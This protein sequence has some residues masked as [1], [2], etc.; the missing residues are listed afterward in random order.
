MIPQ[1]DI[2]SDPDVVGLSVEDEGYKYDAYY[3][4]R[5]M[6]ESKDARLVLRL[7]RSLGRLLESALLMEL[8]EINEFGYWFFIKNTRKLGAKRTLKS[9]VL[10]V[11]SQIDLAI[12]KDATLFI[13]L[14]EGKALDES[15]NEEHRP[16]FANVASKD[17]RINTKQMMGVLKEMA[18]HQSMCVCVKVEGW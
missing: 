4:V 14:D 16:L 18:N 8:D 13:R 17:V 2:F 7:N 5:V 10:K 11:L 3:H 1:D 9:F 6:I 12:K 15:K